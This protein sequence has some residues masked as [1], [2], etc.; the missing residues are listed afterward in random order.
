MAFRPHNRHISK[1]QFADGTTI[2]G[3]RIDNAMQDLVEHV[4]RVPHGDVKDR[5][6]QTQYVMGWSPAKLRVLDQADTRLPW[7]QAFNNDNQL[8]TITGA[9]AV[10]PDAYQNPQRVKGYGV[11]AISPDL[12]G[13]AVAAIKNGVQYVWS[14]P[15]HLGASAIIKSLDVFFMLDTN[16]PG[17][18]PYQNTY[19]FSAL[20]LGVSDVNTRDVSVQI[21]VDRPVAYGSENRRLNQV[22]SNK[23]DFAINTAQML[24]TPALPTQD[25]FPGPYPGGNLSGRWFVVDVNEPVPE[26]SRV[27]LAIVIPDYTLLAP[28]VVAG[29]GVDPWLVQYYSVI[30]TVLEELER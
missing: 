23:R 2:D 19:R 8:A 14:A 26:G 20:P 7:M 25:M 30:L 22:V 9:P 21:L 29:W 5:W 24:H 18:H 11:R 13:S 6:T 17:L 15:I 10:S 3:S 12:E 16:A 28:G 4:N 1:E 27:R